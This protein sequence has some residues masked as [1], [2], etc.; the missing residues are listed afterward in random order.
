MLCVEKFTT[1]ERIISLNNEDK[2][3]IV[4]NKLTAEQGVA[5]PTT[6]KDRVCLFHGS[7][8]GNDDEIMSWEDFDKCWELIAVDDGSG[9]I[10][11]IEA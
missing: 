2:I 8:D 11:E 5:C 9:N 1:M 3:C 6:Y 4:R 10:T 7:G